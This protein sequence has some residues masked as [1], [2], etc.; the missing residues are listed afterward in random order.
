MR[1]YFCRFPFTTASHHSSVSTHSLTHLSILSARIQ[2]FTSCRNHSRPSSIHLQLPLHKPTARP[3]RSNGPGRWAPGGRAG[4]QR[5]AREAHPGQQH[6]R[7]P[8]RRPHRGARALAPLAASSSA[9]GP[10]SAAAVRSATFRIGRRRGRREFYD[11]ARAHRRRRRRGARCVRWTCGTTALARRCRIRSRRSRRSRPST[12][13]PTGWSPSRPAWAD[14]P[15]CR[16]AGRAWMAG[17]E[18]AAHGG[19]ADWRGGRRPAAADC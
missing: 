14:L 11:G 4:A 16:S 2:L 10:D 7:Q 12:S 18:G 9:C 19:S 17:A 8:W 13:G 3:F 6:H 1:R 15:T 5:D